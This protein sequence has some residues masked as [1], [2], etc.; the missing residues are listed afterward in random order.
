MKD[1]VLRA[2]QAAFDFDAR[3]T[4]SEGAEFGAAA[5]LRWRTVWASAAATHTRQRVSPSRFLR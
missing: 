3:I 5:S 4:N 2:E 1:I